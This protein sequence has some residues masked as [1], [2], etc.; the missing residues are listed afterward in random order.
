MGLRQEEGGL[1]SAPKTILAGVLTKAASMA[2]GG[3]TKYKITKL[4]TG[5]SRTFLRVNAH[6]SC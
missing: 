5:P 4:D 2:F 6:A 1:N 3:K